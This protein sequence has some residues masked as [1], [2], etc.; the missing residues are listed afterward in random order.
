MIGLTSDPKGELLKVSIYNDSNTKKFSNKVKKNNKHLQTE[1]TKKTNDIIDF[2]VSSL[3]DSNGSSNLFTL[4][5]NS[6]Y[7]LFW[8]IENMSI[9]KLFLELMS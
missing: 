3:N 8:D 2:C 9:R 4:H 6:Q 5:E 1:L 7:P